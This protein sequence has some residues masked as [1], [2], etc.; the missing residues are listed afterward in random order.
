MGFQYDC[1]LSSTCNHTG[2]AFQIQ[3]GSGALTG[4]VYH[5][6]YCVSYHSFPS[7][8]H[9]YKQIFDNCIK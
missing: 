2:E 3:Y 7:L 4:T 8:L 1:S 6:I 5:D 9:K